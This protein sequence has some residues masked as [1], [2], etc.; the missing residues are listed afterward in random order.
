M[1]TQRLRTVVDVGTVVL[2]AGAIA[3]P[4]FDLLVRDDQARGPAPEFRLA[5]EKPGIPRTAEDL[6]KFPADY[7]AHFGDT[8]GLRDKLLRWNSYEKYFWLDVSP[9]KAQLVG[10][11]GW[12]FYAGDLSMEVV[13]GALPF[14]EQDLALWQGEL[15]GRSRMHAAGGRRYL[16][17]LVPNKE[18]I[19]PERLPMGVHPDG[20]T[21]MDQ[22][23]AWMK[24]HSD[25]D[26]LDL[27]PA[28][29]AA[30]AEDTGPMDPLYTPHGTHWT[31][32]G[33][34]AAYAAIVGHLAEGTSYAGP[35]PFSAFQLVPFPAGADSFASNLYLHGILVQPGDGL[36]LREPNSFSVLEQSDAP[37]SWLRTRGNGANLLPHAIF[38]HDSFGPFISLT[39]A[40]SF[41]ILDMSGGKYERTR[42]DARDTR[43]VV[44]MFVERYL[45]NHV[46]DPAPEPPLPFDDASY[47]ERTHLIFDLSRTPAEAR[48][49]EGLRAT[50]LDGGG[51]RIER[52]ASRDGL[53]LGPIRLPRAGEVRMSL[54]L[55]VETPATLEVLWRRTDGEYFK[56]LDRT[57]LPLAGGRETRETTLP[58]L[59]AECEIMLRPAEN[60]AA[61]DV[62]GLVIRSALPP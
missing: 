18:T 37:P 55:A 9:T 36:F 58:P 3:A 46:P 30:K 29:Q 44:E 20:P 49:V 7:E 62:H 54:D 57:F 13:R 45:R 39:L 42:I 19:Y 2:F 26:V 12:I 53:V 6:Y 52:T 51:L 23:F 48:P 16:F 61:I 34:Y 59:G 1:G 31:S 40:H 11:D 24:Q 4:T 10:K 43:I 25:V 41:S 21:R 17:V 32:R 22:F 27:R 38:F 50:P 47:E 60:G 35:H 15:E 5:A 14:S 33:V 28:F 8:F 56:R